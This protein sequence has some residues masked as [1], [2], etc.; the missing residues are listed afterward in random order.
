MGRLSGALFNFKSSTSPLPVPYLSKGPKYIC[1]R[2]EMERR[3]CVCL[4]VCLYMCLCVFLNVCLSICLC[5]DLPTRASLF[6]CIRLHRCV[7]P[8]TPT[9]AEPFRLRVL[10]TNRL[11]CLQLVALQRQRPRTPSYQYTR[12]YL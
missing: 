9:H 11:T 6:S 2:P 10:P 5:I 8:P 12:T 3:L 4:C 1:M 7:T